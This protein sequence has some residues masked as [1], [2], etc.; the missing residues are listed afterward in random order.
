MKSVNL[1]E[2]ER[3]N[4]PVLREKAYFSTASTGLIPT[5]IHEAIKEYQENRYLIGGDAWWNG[6][7]TSQMM[8]WSKLQIAQMLGCDKDEIAFGDNSSR[9]LNI[10]VNGIRLEPGDN[11]ILA[12][13][14]FI[15]SRFAWQLRERDGIKIKEVNTSSGCITPEDILNA[16][17]E[18]TKVVSL[19]FVESSTGYKYDLAEIGK[20][21]R[22]RGILFCVDGVQGLGIM[23]IDVKKMSI[24]VLVGNDYKWM[25][26]YCGTG[27][28]YFN[29]GL[30]ERI[31]PCGAGWMSDTH[32]YD[33]KKLRLE[34]RADAGRFEMGYPNVSGVYGLGLAAQKYLSLGGGQIR[35]YVMELKSY[36]ISRIKKSNNISLAY[37]F[38]PENQS[39]LTIINISNAY[40]DLVQQLAR[41]KVIIEGSVDSEKGCFTSRIGLHYF[42]NKSDIDKLI[43]AIER[44]ET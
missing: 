29:K 14:T 4:F 2:E 16:I 13:E 10:F 37:E 20:I 26:G 22:E 11:V 8:D 12:D 32:R 39:Q 25:M 30:I 35:E 41:R 17:D 44:S 31:I 28:A 36:L 19:S 1:F 38:G 15:S 27:F 34:L 40:P 23:P 3:M 42:N 18:R 33:T 9:L 24:D 7:N 43:A 21:C 6:M 5:Y